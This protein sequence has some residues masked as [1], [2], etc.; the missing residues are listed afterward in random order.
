MWYVIQVMSGHEPSTIRKIEH[1]A[2][3]KTYSRVFNLKRMQRRKRNGE[4][5]DEVEILFPGYVFVDTKTPRE[6][7]AELTKV[8]ALTKFLVSGEGSDRRFIPI[9]EDEMTLINALVGGEG[10]VMKVSEGVIEGGEVVITS[11]PLL[12]QEALVKK[13]DRHKRLAWLEADMFGRRLTFKV[14]LEIV[15]KS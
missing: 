13:I 3:P 8:A 12:G 11:G 2:D 15:R 14:G 9:S 4:W 6:F 5:T 1:R 10:D 7:C